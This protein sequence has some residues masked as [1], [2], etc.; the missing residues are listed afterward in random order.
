MKQIDIEVLLVC[1]VRYALGRQSY[2]VASVCDIVRS[3]KK[4]SSLCL[5]NIIKDIERA[6]EEEGQG[7]DK[8][9]GNDCDK[10]NW[11]DLLEWCKNK[12]KEERK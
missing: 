3:Q 1:S 12:L 10:Q 9:L 5:D 6:R 4:L 7:I 11:L 2:V 8:P